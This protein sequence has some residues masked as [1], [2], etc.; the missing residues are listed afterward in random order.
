M[1]Y[2]RIYKKPLHHP[3]QV[4]FVLT[5]HVSQ[6]HYQETY[7]NIYIFISHLYFY[8]FTYIITFCW[9]FIFS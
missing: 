5:L 8:Q 9:G 6:C 1:D 7:N 3:Q 2:E 4:G